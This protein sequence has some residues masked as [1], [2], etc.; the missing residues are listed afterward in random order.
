MGE[1]RVLLVGNFEGGAAWVHALSSAGFT[2]SWCQA[3][4]D[5]VTK[6]NAEAID[7]I[8]SMDTLVDLSA[9]QLC[10]LLRANQATTALPFVFIKEGQS[11]NNDFPQ[12]LTYPAAAISLD[13]LAKDSARLINLIQ[14]QAS[15]GRVLGWNGEALPTVISTLNSATDAKQGSANLLTY[16][17]IEKLIGKSVRSLTGVIE[18]HNHFLEAYFELAEG[19]TE[20]DV[21]G[22]AI[23]SLK[24]SWITIKGDSGL[25]ESALYELLSEVKERLQISN[26]PVLEIDDRILNP[27]AQASFEHRT[28]TIPASAAGGCLLLFGNYSGKT[29][30][31][32]QLFAMDALKNQIGPI[33]ELLLTRDELL[34]FQARAQ[35]NAS[36]DQLTG[37]YNLQFFLGFLQ[38][39]LLFSVRHKLP[40]GVLIL[41]IDDF[42]SANA[43]FGIQA[44]DSILMKLAAC[45][46]NSTRASDLSARYGGDEFAVVLPNTDL[47]GA[48]VLAE[49]LRVEIEEI[50]FFGGANKAPSHLTISIGCAEFN[51]TDLNPE[52]ILRDAKH[53]LQKAKEN[54]KN[55]VAG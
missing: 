29:F 21:V 20:A 36:V 35:F 19:L 41:D 30:S 23:G 31:P 13:E 26:E 45:L 53:A 2:L 37:L 24:N 52:T 7:V 40:V 15:L 42:A 43:T 16:L 51:M 32:S 50:P 6:L 49:K 18:P 5:A 34:H 39:Q 12:K 4:L 55:R 47:R 17:L 11:G 1:T 25:T 14:E 22:F 9:S 28:Y 48:Q 10:A 46:L 38:Q 3:G 54:G 27:S 44:G 8:V 33:V